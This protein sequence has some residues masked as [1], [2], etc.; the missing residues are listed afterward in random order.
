MSAVQVNTPKI[1]RKL[2]FREVFQ[3][4]DWLLIVAI[5]PAMLFPE[6]R[7][8][9][10]LLAIPMVMIVQGFVWRDPNTGA[11]LL[12]VTPLNPAILLLEFMVGVSIFVT[13]DLAGSL[14][15]IAGLLFGLAVYFCAARHTRTQQGWRGSLILMIMSSIGIGL[16]GLVG[17]NWYSAKFGG[18]QNLTSSL[19]A[20]IG[21][22]PGA[23]TGIHPN[24]LAG[25]LLWMI[26]VILLAGL[27]LVSEPS[28]FTGK[29]ESGKFQFTQFSGW[30]I[31]LIT[32]SLLSLALLV[33]T[34][35]RGSYLAIGITSL[36]LFILILRGAAR[37]W[38]IGLVAVD[39]LAGAFLIW[40]F[41][42]QTIMSQLVNSL[43]MSDPLSL[44]NSM[45]GRVEIWSRAVWAIRDV[46][47]TG[48]GMNVFRG[49]VSVLYP[50]FHIASGYDIAHAH[51]E[52][53]QAALDL[54]LPGLAGFMALYMGAS[55]MLVPSIRSKGVWRY[56]ALGL[57][58]GLLAHFIFG[59]T[60][61]VALGAKPGFLFWWLLGMV[62]GLYDQNRMVKVE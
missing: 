56:L 45:V 24:E 3:R 23:E 20:R 62:F 58:G 28:W 15:K 42:L 29:P 33:L 47:L 27:A 30:T 50:T 43:S 19:T 14:G 39:A 11:G 7:L 31:L 17:T 26:P 55:A 60:D 40:Q 1:P 54:G 5:A 10:T 41:G 32:A 16:L 61:A 25:V 21:G 9:W 52:L 4:W 53:L 38:A 57:L 12:P 34:Q 35:S 8:A 44:V 46:P 36:V 18:L 59:I 2:K 6:P 22:L 51:N 49:G 37:W 13:P 48:L